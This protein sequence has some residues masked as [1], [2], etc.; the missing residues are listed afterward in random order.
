MR[1]WAIFLSIMCAV[2]VSATAEEYDPITNPRLLGAVMVDW[3]LETC[4]LT[5]FPSNASQLVKRAN[6]AEAVIKSS[7]ARDIRVTRAF[8][9]DSATQYHRGA[10]NA[11]TSW[12]GELQ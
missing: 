1:I 8:I 3:M 10:D 5:S 6:W 2:T 11:C 9:Q 4:P 7:S 12:E